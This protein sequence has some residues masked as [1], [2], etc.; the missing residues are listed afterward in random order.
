VAAVALVL[1]AIAAA[2]SPDRGG[3]AR[4]AVDAGAAGRPVPRSFLGLSTEW[5]SVAPFGGPGHAGVV[6]LLRRV[7]AA[8]GEPLTLRVGGASAEESWWNPAGL[9]PPRPT[10]R[11]AIDP[12]TLAAL[13]GLA[14]GLD[15]PVTVGL[16]LQLGDA[17]N[18]LALARAAERRLRAR[19]EGLEIG[20]EPDLYTVARTFGPVAA[21][22][23]RKRARYAPA[24]YV[25]DAGRYLDVLGAGLRTGPRPRAR[26]VVGGFAGREGWSDALPGLIA[27]HPGEVGAVAAHRYG[28]PGCHLHPDGGDLRR[29]LLST[30]ASRERMASLAPLIALAHR[31]RLPL[32]VAELNSAPCGGAPRVSDSFAAALWLTDALFALVRAGADRADVHTFDGAVYAPFAR[33][34]RAVAPRPPYYGMLAFARAAPRGSRLVPVRLRDAGPVRAWATR[35]SA[36]TLRIALI[37]ASDA[38]RVRV[39]VAAGAGRGCATVRVTSAASLAARAGIAEGAPRRACPRGRVLALVLPGPSLVGVTVPARRG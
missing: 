26:L 19:L 12:S 4:V 22:R 32:R 1:A 10:V 14:R 2:I 38:R 27:A 24:D 7:E 23:L 20:N 5:T 17:R 28:L 13:A 31:N 6:A 16:D 21:R 11:H 9:P 3:P 15:A 29:R 8:A 36:G 35:D 33:R 37:A 30:E 25:R 18:A 34:G 39:L